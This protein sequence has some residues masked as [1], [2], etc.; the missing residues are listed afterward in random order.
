MFSFSDSFL[1][2]STLPHSPILSAPP[3]VPQRAIRQ[4]HQQLNDEI[5]QRRNAEFKHFQDLEGVHATYEQRLQQAH[6]ELQS[7][8]QAASEQVGVGGWLVDVG[9]C[10]W[11]DI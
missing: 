11:A 4:L 9:G 5:A 7:A 1:H 3:F 2:V 6:T 10:C 8:Q